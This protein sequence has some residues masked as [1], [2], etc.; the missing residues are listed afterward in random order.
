MSSRR[1][2]LHEIACREAVSITNFGV[3][4]AISPTEV[5]DASRQPSIF[6]A[7]HSA[8]PHSSTED[9]ASGNLIYLILV[10]DFV[11]RNS[12]TVLF[13]E[14]YGCTDFSRKPPETI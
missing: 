7:M 5:R 3:G 13:A 12:V 11:S 8:A 1:L 6:G 10:P 14:I 4:F 9:D 2:I